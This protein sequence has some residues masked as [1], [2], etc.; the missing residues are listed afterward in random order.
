MRLDDAPFPHPARW[1]RA[2]SG[3]VWRCWRRCPRTCETRRRNVCRF[4]RTASPMGPSAGYGS[5]AGWT[6]ARTCPLPNIRD[7]SFAYPR[8]GSTRKQPQPVQAGLGLAGE[9]QLDRKEE[10][11][12]EEEEEGL[13]RG[14]VRRRCRRCTGRFTGSELCPR[15]DTRCTSYA[16]WRGNVHCTSTCSYISHHRFST[17]L[18]AR[19]CSCL[20]C[21]FMSV[22]FT[23]PPLTAGV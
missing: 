7:T 23:R 11:E 1:T 5:S 22:C 21:L 9:L 20:L 6:L 8:S 18:H 4:W 10:E 12:E 17:R 13:W 16:T 19:V 14:A 15:L 2:P 3:R